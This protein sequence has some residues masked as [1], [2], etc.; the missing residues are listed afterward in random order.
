MYDLQKL[1]TQAL[2]DA[3]N[4]S[5]PVCDSH[6]N[7]I[8]KLVPIGDWALNDQ[9]LL[10]CFSDWRKKFMSLF[11]T[12]FKASVESTIQYLNQ[13]SI[14]QKNRIFF[15]IYIEKTLFGHIGLSNITSNKAELDNMIRGK[16]G[17]HKDLIFFTEKTILEWAFKELKIKKVEAQV[18]SKNFLAKN[19][20]KGFGFTIKERK[21]LKKVYSKSAI[22]L[23]PCDEKDATEK[24]FLDV[25]ELDKNDFIFS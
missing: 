7:I 14:S 21:S 18:L 17:G 23:Q 11:L 6:G 9:N 13:Y 2:E 19:L 1:K 24:F 10:I 3:L 4:L 12:Q 20:H 22:S 5:I 15:G 16:S 8:A 25:M